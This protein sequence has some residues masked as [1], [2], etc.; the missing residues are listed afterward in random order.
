MRIN[1]TNKRYSNVDRLFAMY[2]SANPT[3]YFTPESIGHNG[4]VF[5]EDYQTVD[6]ETSLLPFRHPNGGFWTPNSARST[7][8]FGYVYPETMSQGSGDES[9]EARKGNKPLSRQQRVRASIAQLYGSSARAKLIGH[10]ATAG[11]TL[12]GLDGGFVDWTINING[13]A[14]YLPSTFVVRFELAED[15]KNGVEDGGVDVGSWVRAMPEMNHP[16][17]KVEQ[18]SEGTGKI[19]EGRVG[20]TS[21]LLD[22]I[23]EGSLASLEP[24]DVVPYLKKSLQWKV[25]GVSL[26][27]HLTPKRR[28][29]GTNISLGQRSPSPSKGSQ[30]LDDRSRQHRGTHPEREDRAN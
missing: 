7:E 21:S 30:R 5:L 16:S 2:Q 29:S 19:Y 15:S 20:L 14:A 9:E 24:L 18:G 28:R 3:T 1:G 10:A 22:K 12:L 8:T 13:T 26:L 4:N 17:S 25:I 23:G 27:S 6:A 11:G